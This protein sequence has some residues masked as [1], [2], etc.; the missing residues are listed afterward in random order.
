MAEILK[1]APVAAALTETIKNKVLE[2]KNKGIT[3]NMA[4]LR[5]GNREDDIAYERGVLKRCE[6]IG[7]KVTHILL[8]EDASKEDVLNEIK[9]I[10]EDDNIQGCLMFRPLPDKETEEEACKLL[11]PKKDLDCMTQGSLATVFSG[12]GEGHAPCTAEAVMELLKFY[13]YDLTGKK[14]TVIGRS[15]VIGKPVSMMLLKENATVTMCHTRTVDLPKVCKEADIL[16]VAAGKAGV[17]DDTFVSPGQVVIDVGIN[18]NDEGKLCG[19]VDFEKVE[20]IVSAITPVPA[21]VGSVT[22]AVLAGHLLRG[23][24][25]I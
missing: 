24:S 6:T 15:L 1:G 21:G 7:I 10:N 9:R 20:P 18:V 8:D 22:T 5:V 17:V 14:V 2:L 23:A 12:F 16:V 3:S 25:R 13:G 19:D 4:V 11:S